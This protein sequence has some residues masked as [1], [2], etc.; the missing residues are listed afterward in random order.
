MQMVN[1]FREGISTVID[2]NSAI[3]TI[4]MT[5][6]MTND[7]MN[8]LTASSQKMAKEMGI[9]ISEVLNAVKVYANM[10][11][12]V[13]K[14]L[15]KT[16]A[17]IQLATASG[18]ST[19][20]TTDAIQAILNQYELEAT[21]SAER[22]ADTLEMVSANMPMDFQRGIQQIVNGIRVSGT[23]AREAG[24]DLERYESVLGSIIARTRLQGSQI[25]NALKTVFAR[26]GRVSDPTEA[27]TE[28]ISKSETAYRKLGIE[29]R[30]SLTGDFRD[31][32]DV[33]DELATKWSTLT[34]IQKNYIAEV[35]YLPFKVVIL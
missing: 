5:M 1:A 34:K 21:G 15:E 7:D 28:D 26:L 2:L 6:G 3:T 11:E 10:S 8:N 29:I 4:H 30:D 35:K 20:D 25:G 19:T 12:S 23:V 32:P 14:I 31:V 16:K 27:S 24:F 18:M 33:L 13:E 17:D 22:I 9:A